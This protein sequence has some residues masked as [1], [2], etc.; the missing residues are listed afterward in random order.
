MSD[1]FVRPLLSVGDAA[2]YIADQMLVAES[3]QSTVV[4]SA[5]LGRLRAACFEQPAHDGVRRAHGTAPMP[6]AST[7]AKTLWSF[8]P[9][10]MDFPYSSEAVAKENRHLFD[11][12]DSTVA[13]ICNNGELF[14]AHDGRDGTLINGDVSGVPRKFVATLL[15]KRIPMAAAIGADYRVY[16]IDET[17]LRV[18][19]S[20]HTNRVCAALFTKPALSLAWCAEPTLLAVSA[21]ATLRTFDLRAGQVAQTFDVSGGAPIRQVTACPNAP[22]LATLSRDG[23]VLIFDCRRLAAPSVQQ[24]LFRHHGRD[25]AAID[26]HPTMRNTLTMAADSLQYFACTSDGRNDLAAPPLHRRASKDTEQEQ[27][28][29]LDFHWLDDGQQMLLM[30]KTDLSSFSIE[31]FYM[32]SR[33]L[34]STLQQSTFY[35][36]PTDAPVFAVRFDGTNARACFSTSDETLYSVLL[37]RAR[38]VPRRQLRRPQTA[39]G[40]SALLR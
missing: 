4:S 32:S 35:S 5:H 38:F 31:H 14:L 13:A 22:T 28:K 3:G 26:W 7:A 24:A 17:T 25:I 18:Q 39:F 40:G 9:R 29:V 11:C 30:S 1:R 23:S 2:H 10:S 12:R 16:T 36:V 20:Q 33:H 8:E 34:C 19:Q 6:F 37:Q 21:A 15:H 27:R